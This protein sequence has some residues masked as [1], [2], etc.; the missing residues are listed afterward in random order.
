MNNPPC[1]VIKCCGFRV[2]VLA[3][4][5]VLWVLCFC[6]DFCVSVVSF[7]FLFGFSVT[8]VGFVFLL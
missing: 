2:S 8:V 3:F 4:V 5:L 1:W 6:C 7:V